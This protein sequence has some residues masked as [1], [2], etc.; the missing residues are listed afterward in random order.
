[1]LGLRTF[2]RPAPLRKKRLV[3]GILD[4]LQTSIDDGT[5][6]AD[7]KESV[8]VASTSSFSVPSFPVITQKGASCS[9]L[10]HSAMR[11]GSI[12]HRPHVTRTTIPILAETSFPNPNPRRLPQNPRTIKGRFGFGSRSRSFIFDDDTGTFSLLGGE[13]IGGRQSGGGRFEDRWEQKDGREG[14]RRGY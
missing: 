9:S 2:E 10:S 13:A 1:M 6:R 11:F 5:I 8:E 4:F 3:F 12:R 7:D 14:L